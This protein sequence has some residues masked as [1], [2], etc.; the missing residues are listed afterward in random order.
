MAEEKARA[1]LFDSKGRKRLRSP[2]LIGR[3]LQS[4]L[5]SLLAVGRATSFECEV[6]VGFTCQESDRAEKQAKALFPC[7]ALTV[8]Y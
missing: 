6:H 4:C 8:R 1:A 7:K 2:P 3:L 5:A